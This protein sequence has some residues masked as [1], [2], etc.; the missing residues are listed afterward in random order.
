[1]TQLDRQD[2]DVT[3]R[4]LGQ[5]R[6]E[7]S[8]SSADKDRLR[9]VLGL[10]ASSP[11]P[12][13][14]EPAPQ[15]ATPVR[16]TQ[17]GRLSER[18]A[19]L[20]SGKLGASLAALLFGAGI[21]VGWSLQGATPAEAPAAPPSAAVAPL[22]APTLPAP[23]A[24]PAA[25]PGDAPTA[26]LPAEATRAPRSARRPRAALGATPQLER[27]LDAELA[28][29]RRVERALRNNDAAL[30]VAL[31]DELD[32]RFP[33]TRLAEERLAAR[34][35][36]GCRLDTPDAVAQA[37]AFLRERPASVY[38]ERVRLACALETTTT[39]APH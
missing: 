3:E 30:A 6:A 4:A 33:Q 21:A 34:R 5:L 24:L 2:S 39:G 36:A 32:N 19:V 8:P 14:E 38:S 27:P 9:R 29:L 16:L 23:A 13:G 11:A 37:R 25:A 17:P 20:A 1:M 7:L 10:G 35:M 12:V 26:R 15:L 18:A 28:L 31:L 22:A